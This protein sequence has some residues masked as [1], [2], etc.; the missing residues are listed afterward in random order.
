MMEEFERYQEDETNLLDI[1]SRF[2]ELVFT[3]FN[4]ILIGFSAIFIIIL[5]YLFTTPK[6]YNTYAKIK[7]LEEEETSAFVLEDMMNFDSPFKED[8]LLENEIEILKSKNILET[9]IKELRL[10]HNYSQKT[11]LPNGHIDYND[12]P[13]IASIS[14]SDD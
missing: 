10:T 6:E 11:I 4:Y 7:V 3:N 1:I 13:F 12:I 5:L 2:K 9:V 8:E 14:K